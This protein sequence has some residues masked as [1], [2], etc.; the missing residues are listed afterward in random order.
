LDLRA[1]QFKYDKGL[2]PAS[3]PYL[4]SLELANP[5][6]FIRGFHK[7]VSAKL[8]TISEACFGN[9]SYVYPVDTTTSVGPY[10]LTNLFDYQ[11]RKRSDVVDKQNKLIEPS[12]LQFL[13]KKFE[14]RT[15]PFR[16]IIL[17]NDK[18]EVR[19][20]KTLTEKVGDELFELT[21][22]LARKF[23]NGC[24]HD[25]V[26]D[27]VLLGDYIS[28]AQTN[29]GPL[30]EDVIGINPHGMSWAIMVRQLK[31]KKHLIM[32]DIAGNDHNQP[33]STVKDLNRLIEKA[34]GNLYSTEH[35]NTIQSLQHVDVIEGRDVFA[36][37]NVG[38][39]SGVFST[40]VFNGVGVT[41]TIKRVYYMQLLLKLGPGFHTKEPFHKH[42][43][44]KSN[45]DDFAMSVDD[46][47][48][49]TLD[50]NLITLIEKA[51]LISG[52]TITPIKKESVPQKEEHWN[53]LELIQRKDRV[54]LVN[55]VPYHHGVLN[56][57][58]IIKSLYFEKESKSEHRDDVIDS[59]LQSAALEYMHHGK[60]EFS[61]F[62]SLIK[63]KYTQLFPNRCWPVS[64]YEHYHTNWINNYSDFLTEHSYNVLFSQWCM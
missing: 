47:A 48:F 4:D 37:D 8:L 55:G 54:E 49:S 43:I 9:G 17:C 62:V 25:Y 5:D 53:D 18:N 27:R 19:K 60:E 6:I 24:F 57:D 38:T 36:V 56:K 2:R 20:M 15:K 26:L 40:G 13:D 33:E 42:C 41:S 16:R 51:K 52:L 14:D 50:F 61:N 44:L 30:Q 3:I 58:S 1:H 35:F 7:P 32:G 31:T 10:H 63:P 28:R 23:Y 21:L 22:P 39:I 46:F 12:F 64:T 45:G 34:Y 59:C 11:I 29:V